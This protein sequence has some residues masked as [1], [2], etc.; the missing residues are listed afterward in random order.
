MPLPNDRGLVATLL[1][2][3]G[4]SLLTSVESVLVFHEP[5]EVGMLAGLNDRPARTAQGIRHETVV[6]TYSL[7]GDPVQIGSRGNLA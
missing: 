4:K 5:V 2:E 1:Q 7:L 3:L 6:E